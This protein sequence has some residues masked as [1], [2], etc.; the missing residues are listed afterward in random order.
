MLFALSLADIARICSHDLASSIV[1]MFLSIRFLL[2]ILLTSRRGAIGP[3]L[4]MLINYGLIDLPFL[5]GSS[6]CDEQGVMENLID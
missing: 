5:S 3:I 4:P 6:Y 2:F 1:Y